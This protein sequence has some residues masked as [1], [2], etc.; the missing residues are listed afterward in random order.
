M[1]T[2]TDRALFRCMGGDHCAHLPGTCTADPE[3]QAQIRAEDGAPAPDAAGDF[4]PCERT[5]R[6]VMEK[7]PL[8]DASRNT[9][10]QYGWLEHQ[11]QVK[12]ILQSLM[13]LEDRADYLVREYS[14]AIPTWPGF[15]G[16][17]SD[18]ENITRWF[19]ETGAIKS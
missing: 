17:R 15:D 5:L 10:W 13:P 7:L 2:P 4:V 18:E 9:A 1:T 16:T 14:S 11:S 12:T 3:Y 6:L 8:L 19:I